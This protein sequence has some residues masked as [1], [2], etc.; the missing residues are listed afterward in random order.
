MWGEHHGF[1]APL[2]NA[3][4]QLTQTPD[5]NRFVYGE[6]ALNPEILKGELKELDT[7]ICWVNDFT[8]SDVFNN[9]KC[10]VLQ[11]LTKDI[12]TA[13][14]HWG[15]KEIRYTE[16]QRVFWFLKEMFPNAKFIVL[17]RNP[18]DTIV[19]GLLAWHQGGQQEVQQIID[20][21]ITAWVKKYTYQLQ[22]AEKYPDDSLI[23]RYEDLI[24]KPQTYM[25]QVFELIET[26]PVA[27][28][29]PVFAKKVAF[30][31]N[32]PERDELVAKVA[33]ALEGA[34]PDMDTIRKKYYSEV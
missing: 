34:G 11:L 20:N 3:Y 30:T 1:L 19:S 26:K 27:D 7:D 28:V 6:E 21:K 10:L 12:D 32:R 4:F 25:N 15:F 9:F 31:Q 29:S 18:V 5:M 23:I 24:D 13:K 2:S 33:A 14:I 8:K 16:N 22:E 17:L